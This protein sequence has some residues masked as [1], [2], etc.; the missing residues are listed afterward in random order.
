VGVSIYRPLAAAQ[1]ALATG[2]FMAAE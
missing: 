1:P 2:E